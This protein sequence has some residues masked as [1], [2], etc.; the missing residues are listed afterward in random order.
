MSGSLNPLMLL[1][2][3][4]LYEKGY[5]SYNEVIGMNFTQLQDRFFEIIRTE[6]LINECGCQ[7]VEQ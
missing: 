2:A 6:A 5:N 1:Y 3:N 7:E 4:Y